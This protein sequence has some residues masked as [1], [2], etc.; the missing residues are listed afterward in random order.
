[1]YLLDTDVIVDVLRQHP[2]AVQWTSTLFDDI[3]LP[4]FVM[5][6]VY[7]GCKDRREMDLLERSLRSTRLIWPSTNACNAA[8]G[9]YQ[10]LRLSC[11]IGM[12]DMLIAQT[13]I[14]Y[15]LPL[16]TF[17]RKHFVHV[18]R[19]ITLQPYTR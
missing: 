2:P 16:Y 4:G 19:L 7:S 10:T 5:M 9:Q 18:P 14:E 15:D 1:M 12:V 3:V 6:E 13:A 17:N 8:L 11:G